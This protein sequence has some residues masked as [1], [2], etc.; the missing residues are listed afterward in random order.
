MMFDLRSAWIWLISR[1]RPI[2][3]RRPRPRP[4]RCR[5]APDHPPQR[6][7]R[8]GSASGR[9]QYGCSQRWRC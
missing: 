8:A 5:S 3:S 2:S 1:M 4:A 7:S 6:L 9:G